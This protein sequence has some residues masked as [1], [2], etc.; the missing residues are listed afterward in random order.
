MLAES[1]KGKG[2]GTVAEL[3]LEIGTEELPA[4]TVGPALEQLAHG[5]RSALAEAL[6]REPQVTTVGTH[7]RL[8]VFVAELPPSQPAREEVV[9]GPPVRIAL[10][11]DGQ[12]T[13]AALG[14]ARSQALTV[15]DLQVRDTPK[16][17]YLCAVKQT[18]GRPTADLLCDL[19]PPLIASLSFPKSMYWRTPAFRFARPVRYILALLDTDVLPLQAAGLQ[20]GRLTRGHPFLAPEDISLERADFKKYLESLGAA[21]VVADH[22]RRREE[23]HRA[24]AEATAKHGGRFQ[25]EELLD[26]VTFLVELVNV[27]EGSFPEEYLELPREVLEAAMKNHQRYFPVHDADG[28]LIPRFLL[29]SNRPTEADPAVRAGNERVLV[30]RLFDAKF[31][32]QE[33]LKRPLRDRMADLDQLIVQDKLGSYREKTDR[34]VSLATGLVAELGL[35]E[36]KQDEVR[37][38]A[39]LAKADLT[40][41]MVAELPE[42][43][44]IMGGEYARAEGEPEA[45]AR[46]IREQYLPRQAD[47]PVPSTDDG[48]I[49]ALA[50]R[51]DTLAGCF[52]VGLVPTGSADPYALRRAALGVLRILIEKQYLLL[53]LRRVLS[54][55]L[56]PF[57]EKAE[58]PPEEVLDDLLV[59]FRD[60]LTNLLLEKGHELELVRAA[61]AVGYDDV[62][63]TVH[64]LE[65]LRELAQE[66][67]WRD[68]VK[69]VERTHNITRDYTGPLDV[70]ESSL[71][72]PEEEKLWQLLQEQRDRIGQSLDRRD[73]RNA[74]QVFART[75]AQPLHTFFDQVFVNV[76]D[77]ALRNNRLALLKNINLLISSRFADLSQVHVE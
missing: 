9:T 48:A 66:P 15:D 4:H 3:L 7:R 53:S 39:E 75:F 42:L 26:E 63:D 14:F 70:D 24:L 47:D 20:A 23:L 35:S 52:A 45:V 77:Q 28:N 34:L 30:A 6:D 73:Y 32:W 68:L 67:A 1:P 10:D 69:A 37:R 36:Q 13:Q 74:A 22:H 51:L 40:T 58:R 27:V 17:Q 44:G 33:D 41:E 56:E 5:L 59:F 2:K 12:P 25:E 46:A 61:L 71:Q 50:D 76:D 16:G 55:A 72:Q 11:E 60:R 62:T 8:T 64:R 54:N 29:A 57:A 21:G 31:F 18:P 43:Q 65:A 49:L 38:A 19:L